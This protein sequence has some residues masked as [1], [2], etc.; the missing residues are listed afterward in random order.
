MGIA[1][2]LGRFA[3]GSDRQACQFAPNMA[4]IRMG[5]VEER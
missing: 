4:G 3:N 5:V 2:N 1:N